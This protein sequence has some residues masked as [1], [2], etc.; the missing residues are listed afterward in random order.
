MLKVNIC[1]NGNLTDI[2]PHGKKNKNHEVTFKGKRSVKDLIQSFGIPHTEVQSIAVNGKSVDFSY[3]LQHDDRIKVQ[4][5][6]TNAA[7]YPGEP[8]LLCD[9]HLHKLC[10]RL[11]LLGFDTAFNREWDDSRLA[12]I[13][14]KEGRIL[15]SR[16]RGLLMRKKV[17]RGLLIRST[18]SEEQ[19]HEVLERLDLKNRCRPFSR[20]LLC[21]GLLRKV[22]AGEE[23]FAGIKNKIPGKVLAWCSVYNVCL[24]CGKIYWKGSHYKKLAEKVNRYIQNK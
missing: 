12:V 4:P 22:A 2:L 17:S 16:D 18:D 24:S 15:L 7:V 10:R 1:F 14:E 23:S 5:V 8:A 11:R 6:V 3:I 20:C 9:E 21:S 19:V 13:S